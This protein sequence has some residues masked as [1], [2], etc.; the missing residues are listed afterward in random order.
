M[1]TNT[2]TQKQ[3]KTYQITKNLNLCVSLSQSGCEGQ[4]ETVVSVLS[5]HIYM[6]SR[7]QTQ[8]VSLAQQTLLPLEPSYQPYSCPFSKQS[9]KI[10]DDSNRSNYVMVTG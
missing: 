7:D 6:A 3:T 5:F 10:I 8:V 9:H 2:Y 4:R 1:Y